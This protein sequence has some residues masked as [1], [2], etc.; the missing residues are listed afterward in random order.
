MIITII[1]S[2]LALALGITVLHKN[3]HSKAN[4]FFFLFT[5]NI[6]LWAVALGLSNTPLETAWVINWTI[7][8][9]VV[10][11]GLPILF[12]AFSSSLFL[13][14]KNISSLYYVC[15]F[16]T[17]I[18]V[19]Y[20]FTL[21][22]GLSNE[23]MYLQ[24]TIHVSL[25]KTFWVY[26]LC[27]FGWFVANIYILILGLQQNSGIDRLKITLIT[28][29]FVPG[30]VIAVF[31]NLLLPLVGNSKYTYLSGPFLTTTV[32]FAITYSI[33][34]HRLFD[35]QIQ[36]QKLLNALIPILGTFIAVTGVAYWLIEY[37]SLYKA[38]VGMG[39][40]IM[41]IAVYKALE[42]V[43]TKTK[44]SHILFQKTY[45]FHQALLQLANKASTITD[46]E[47]L[48]DKIADVFAHQGRI[49]QFGFVIITDQEH[50]DYHI[51]K[52][53]GLPLKQLPLFSKPQ[54]DDWF[55]H[56]LLQLSEPLLV[57]ELYYA[58]PTGLS[59]E[60]WHDLQRQLESLRGGVFIP[61]KVSHDLVGCI[62]LGSKERALAYTSEDLTVFTSISTPLA[63]AVTKSILFTQYREKITE[64]SLEK[65]NLQNSML[66]LRN[67]KS[68]FLNIVDHQFNTPLSVI[69][70]AL[71]M[72]QEGD[73]PMTEIQD[74]LKDINPRVEEFH[75]IIQ[76][77]IE[78]AHF[79]GGTAD[80]HFAPVALPALLNEVV[81][82]LQPRLTKHQV[83]L[84]LNI[85]PTVQRITSDP[86]K[87]K[88][89]FRHLL[90]NAMFFGAGQPIEIQLTQPH[91]DVIVHIRDYGRGFSAEEAKHIGQKFYRGKNVTDFHAN[92]SGL[93]IYNVRKIIKASGGQFTFSSAGLG[94]GSVFTIIFPKGTE[95]FKQTRL[96]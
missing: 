32:S 86:E 38:Y 62:V 27:F 39:L 35:I 3:Y 80:M 56:Y 42:I 23:V 30:S 1:T 6:S 74:Y 58:Q 67:M 78:A 14:R 85:D 68:E 18:I 12:L 61:L 2:L 15:A 29:S 89:A 96:K 65:N 53:T 63:V 59:T 70:G 83:S 31:F 41:S 26:L 64:L 16:F 28:W 5:V 79:E 94:K 54:L 73:V 92:G 72:V 17:V 95:F 19:L 57:D 82:E 55:Y 93:G 90:E 48:I 7:I 25:G 47:Q 22:H 50:H 21:G 4:L 69:R 49:Q 75:H 81:A 71:S 43:A 24:N 9:W 11:I 91:K 76:S 88:F 20:I 34:R 13:K 44:L 46:F 87:L 10:S 37:T 51:Y 8:T 45:R 52:N 84:K 60:A 36:T 40:I 66:E 77:M 33:I